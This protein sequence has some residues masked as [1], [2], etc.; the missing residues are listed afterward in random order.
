MWRPKD[1]ENPYYKQA[2]EVIK[3]VGTYTDGGYINQ[4][5]IVGS[6]YEAGADAM[7]EELRA[8]GG[9]PKTMLGLNNLFQNRKVVFIPDEREVK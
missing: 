1:W 4:I 5:K 3:V 8:M 6:A 9:E 7:L 2:E